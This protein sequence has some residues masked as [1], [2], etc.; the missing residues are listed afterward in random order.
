MSV[1]CDTERARRRA[2]ARDGLLA[3]LSEVY[4]GAS[5]L[6]A[7]ALLDQL[8]DRDLHIGADQ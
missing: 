2:L 3:A 4:A 6:E 1:A 8:A 7:D 5:Y